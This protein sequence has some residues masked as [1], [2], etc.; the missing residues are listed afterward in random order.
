MAD[1]LSSC[2]QTRSGHVNCGSTSLPSGQV[3][4][5]FVEEFGRESTGVYAEL[6][7]LRAG[8][9]QQSAAMPSKASLQM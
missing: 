2:C 3:S 9:Q 7:L 6:Y 4:R 5:Q 8:S 1:R